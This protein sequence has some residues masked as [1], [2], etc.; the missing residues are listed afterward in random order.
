MLLTKHGK[1]EDAEKLMLGELKELDLSWLQIGD[2]EVVKV[3]AFLKVDATV[4]KVYLTDCNIG[5]R[6]AKAIAVAVKHNRTVWWLNLSKNQ[7]GDESADSLIDAL[8]QNVCLTDLYV[9]FSNVT[10]E[11]QATINT[12]PKPATRP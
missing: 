6:G 4:K 12:S 8:N 5:P 10:R 2:D 9:S 7:L 3:A 11:S 1:R